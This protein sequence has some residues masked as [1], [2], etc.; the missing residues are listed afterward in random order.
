VWFKAILAVY[1]WGHTGNNA[2]K[3]G[4]LEARLLRA[5]S[6][7]YPRASLCSHSLATATYARATS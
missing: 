5:M 2:E 1:F 3:G 6:T 4:I 7:Q